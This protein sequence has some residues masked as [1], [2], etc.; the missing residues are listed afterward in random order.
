MCAYFSKSEDESSEAMKQAAKEASK[1]NLNVFEQMKAIAK[2]YTTKREC[3]VQ[4]AVYHI[5]P[6]LWLRKTFPGVIFANSNL[7][8]DRYRICRNEDEIK[9]MS[10]DSTDIFKR[11]MLDRY[12]DRPNLTYLGGKYSVLDQFCY[13]EFFAHYYLPSRQ[14]D[15]EEND[16]QTPKTFM[17]C[18]TSHAQLLIFF[19]FFLRN[20]FRITILQHIRGQQIN[21]YSHSPT[22]FF[23]QTAV[24][25]RTH[26]YSV[27]YVLK[28]TSLSRND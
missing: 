4:E 9:E 3:S 26:K 1:M 22:Y 8:E 7:P 17:A 28:A 10:K 14:V 13:A 2:A 15:D 19:F 12:V 18:E 21:F 27:M 24:R 6:E 20:I 11:N 5:M 16:N 23:F 25:L